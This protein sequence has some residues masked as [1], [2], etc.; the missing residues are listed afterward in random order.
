MTMSANQLKNSSFDSLDAMMQAYASEAVRTASTQHGVKLDY[1][2][3]S[4]EALENILNALD[5]AKENDLEWLTRLWGSYFGE[6]F[7]RR[8]ASEW[9]M[10]DYPGSQ[11]AVPALDIGGSR[12]YPL[13]KVH[14]RLTMGSGE[15]LTTFL[16][17]VEKR[18][19]KKR[20]QFH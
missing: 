4:V 9:V 12:I 3:D 7:R 11:F 17:M 20:A 5:M 16:Q 8:Y 13:M 6:I 15:S 18:L 1:S 2:I 19:E 14:R 10:S